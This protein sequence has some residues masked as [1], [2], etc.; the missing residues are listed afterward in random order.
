MKGII[1]VRYCLTQEKNTLIHQNLLLQVT[2]HVSWRTVALSVHRVASSTILTFA[3]P[4][5]A[6]AILPTGAA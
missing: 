1:L 3:L 2:H 4:E 5:A 6:L